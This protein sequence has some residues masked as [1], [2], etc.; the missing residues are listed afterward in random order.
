MKNAFKR[1]VKQQKTE[2][3]ETKTL[4]QGQIDTKTSTGNGNVWVVCEIWLKV[5]ALLKAIL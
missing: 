2:V 1:F 5:F 4:K 3:K